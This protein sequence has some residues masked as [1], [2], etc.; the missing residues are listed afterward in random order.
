M[1][2]AEDAVLV[3]GTAHDI[4]RLRPLW[5]SVHHQH[6]AVMPGLA[7]FVDDDTTWAERASLYRALLAKPD[8]VLVV[9]EIDNRTVGY[10]LAHVMAARDTWL[11]DTWVTG[12]RVGEIESLAVEPA[13][14]GQGLG[15]RLFNRLIDELHEQG[16]E[17]HV[18]G[19]LPDNVDAI[20]LYQRHG[21]QPAWMYLI[22]RP[23]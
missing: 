8:S 5:V 17:D 14:R 21:Y 1:S 20:R 13:L 9:A 16:V 19:V 3:T 11:A 15:S 10:G 4:P 2:V 22:N 23:G 6:Q 12:Q 7:P 18:I